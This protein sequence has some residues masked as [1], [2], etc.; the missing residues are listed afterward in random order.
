[1]LKKQ[2]SIQPKSNKW[3]IYLHLFIN[4]TM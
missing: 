3:I 1:L 4:S 2:V